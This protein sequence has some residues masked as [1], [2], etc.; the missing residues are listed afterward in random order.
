MVVAYHHSLYVEHLVQHTE[1]ECRLVRA[2]GSVSHLPLDVCNLRYRQRNVQPLGLNLLHSQE[3]IL[4]G[5]A[6]SRPRKSKA[7]CVCAL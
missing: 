5:G 4:S 2:A 6:M 1:L 7:H 3:V